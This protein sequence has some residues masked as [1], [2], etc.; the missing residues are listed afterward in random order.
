M[1]VTRQT[2]GAAGQPGARPRRREF[3]GLPL[4]LGQLVAAVRDDEGPRSVRDV[5][6]GAVAA[7]LVHVEPEPVVEVGE[8]DRLEIDS[9]VGPGT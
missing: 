9:R 3:L 6:E 5:Q 4:E 8:A 7:R 2:H 1:V